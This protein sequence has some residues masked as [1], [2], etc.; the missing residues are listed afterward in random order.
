VRRQQLLLWLA[1]ICLALPGTPLAWGEE[2]P[3]AVLSAE[4]LKARILEDQR[5]IHSF[6]VEYQTERGAYPEPQNP[7]GSY[8][9][10][11]VAAKA[12]DRMYYVN[13]HGFDG[14][15]WRDDPNH[16][17]WYITPQGWFGASPVN[18][19]YTT[20]WP[21][22]EHEELPGEIAQDF[23]FFATGL[24]VYDQHQPPRLDGRPIVLREVA[25]SPAYRTVRPRQELVD[26]RWCHVLENEG[27]ERLWIDIEHGCALLARET[28]YGTP[29]ALAQRLESG[30]HRE[31]A[32][33]VWLP[34]RMR[35]IQYYWRAR[36]EAG[37]KRQVLNTLNLVLEA[38]AND[39]DD[40][41]F[42]FRQPPGAL[43]VSRP[44]DPVQTQPG[45]LDDYVEHLAGWIQSHKQVMPPAFK[46][47]DYLAGLPALALIVAFELWLY[48]RRN[49][50]G[51]SRERSDDPEK[52]AIS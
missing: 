33:G 32:P 40:G 48:W 42:E 9:H 49:R 37:R 14:L 15:D 47:G 28:N 23:F 7:P 12:P 17:H 4:Q 5:K 38:R 34:S 29:P 6:Y 52:R 39:V 3:A 27:V 46:V 31:V 10:R 51:S 36:T 20:G 26:G 22:G 43:D 45:G 19:T 44:T 41:L 2:P 21:L 50:G 25:T 13:A 11:V 8:L 24:W 35:N 1:G 18:R 30:G 16:K